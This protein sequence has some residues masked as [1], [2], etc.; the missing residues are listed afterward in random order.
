MA[1]L[2]TITK[3][4]NGYF[5]FVLNGDSATEIKN[6]RNDLLT[7]GDICHFKT[8]NGANLIKE[9]DV[10]YFNVTIIDGMTSLVPIS[11]DDLF[12][13]LISVDFFA[14]INGTGSG[15]DRFDELADTFNYFGNNGKTAIVDESQLKLIPASLPNT[16]KLDAFPDVLEP[17][18]VLVVNSTGDGYI[19]VNP[20]NSPIEVFTYDRLLAPQQDF[21]IPIGKVAKW[22]EVNYTTYYLEDVTNTSEFNTFT[23]AGNTVTFKDPLE[24]GNYPIIYLQ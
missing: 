3:E 4:A 11:V 2:L 14:W 5:S 24:I 21:T 12:T 23:Q 8:S 19:L 7:I 9:Q 18:K 10:L 22:A 13:K 17:N 1:N 20:E 15:V 16:E 6:T